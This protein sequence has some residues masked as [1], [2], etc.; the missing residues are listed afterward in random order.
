MELRRIC[1]RFDMDSYA[2]AW[3]DLEMLRVAVERWGSSFGPATVDHSIRLAQALLMNNWATPTALPPCERTRSGRL[4]LV[5]LVWEDR[6]DEPSMIYSI[7][8]TLD[9]ANA[10]VGAN[11][12]AEITAVEMDGKG[13]TARR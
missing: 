10:L 11:L 5:Y 6:D 3:S 4:M 12:Q 9:A 1:G 7:C 13:A 8:S 2:Q